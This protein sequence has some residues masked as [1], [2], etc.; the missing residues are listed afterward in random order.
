MVFSHRIAALA[1]VVAS[2]LG[3]AATSFALTDTPQ[4]PKV[5]AEVELHS[6]S[7]TPASTR[8]GRGPPGERAARPGSRRVRQLR[9]AGRRSRDRPPLHRPSRLLREFL[10]RQYADPDEELLGLVGRPGR[11]PAQ[12]IQPRDL[13]VAVP[14]HEDT[15][16]RRRVFD[17]PDSTGTVHRASGE[18]RWAKVTVARAGGEAEAAFVV[19]FHPGANRPR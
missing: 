15:G 12:I 18:I 7:P 10:V 8:A 11:N 2:P 13:P 9:G 17:S 3:I 19:A 5:P 6:G 1:A 4:P 16:A 14:L